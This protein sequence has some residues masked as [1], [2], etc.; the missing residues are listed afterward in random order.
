MGVGPGVG[1][2]QRHMVATGLILAGGAVVLQTSLYAL[3]V[4]G[5][6]RTVH[7]FDLEEGGLVTWATSSTTFSSAV[8][9]LILGLIDPAQKLRGPALAAGLA[10]IS[11]DDAV[12]LHERIAYRIVAELDV[13]EAYVQVIWPVLYL[14]LLVAIAVLLLGLARDTQP[15]HRLVVAGLAILVGAVTL[16]VA[17]HALSQAGVQANSWPWVLA[18]SL[19]EG[20]ELVGWILIAIGAAIRLVAVAKETPGDAVPTL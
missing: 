20:A 8:L 9:V 17:G 6:N 13:S 11:F 7:M 18:T 1:R 14:P 12:F 2:D 19:E 16:E 4:Y 3:N 15:A 5:L 10:F